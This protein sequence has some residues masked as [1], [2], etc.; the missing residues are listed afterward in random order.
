M[1]IFF[2]KL[3][4]I[5]FWVVAIFTIAYLSFL[6]ILMDSGSSFGDPFAIIIYCIV[7]F[8]PTI[9]LG[10]IRVKLASNFKVQKYLRKARHQKAIKRIEIN[11]VKKRNSLSK[12]S[13]RKNIDPLIY[14]VKHE[15]RNR[16]K[17]I[18][19]YNF[20]HLETIINSARENND[21]WSINELYEI[22]INTKSKNLNA[23]ISNYINNRGIQYEP[24]V[25]RI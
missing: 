4:N 21:I 23:E 17:Y 6:F 13:D 16:Q 3:F 9:I 20:K 18:T 25:R 24:D 10:L 2:Y 19:P 1:I 7:H 5:F 14:A 22:I 12:N 8:I 11:E 15:L